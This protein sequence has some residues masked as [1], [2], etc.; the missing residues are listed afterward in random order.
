[1]RRIYERSKAKSNS[2]IQ[3]S[4]PIRLR[5]ATFEAM[6]CAMVCEGLL[7]EG[8]VEEGNRMSLL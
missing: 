6:S 1:M 3:G 8:L 2:E 4:F 7:D 5:L